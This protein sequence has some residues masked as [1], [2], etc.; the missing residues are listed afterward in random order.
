MAGEV[1][2]SPRFLSIPLFAAEVEGDDDGCDNH[3]APGK[4][5]AVAPV[6]FRHKFEVHT[7]YTYQEGERNEDSRHDGEAFHD[8][9]HPH[10]VVR[11]VEVGERC[12]CFAAY[13]QSLERE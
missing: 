5:I 2:L 11:D 13:F 9:V 6:E 4:E 1:P 3:D 10:V 7:P 8:G 12:E